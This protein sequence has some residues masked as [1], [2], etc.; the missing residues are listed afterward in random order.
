MASTTAITSASAP[1]HFA[2]AS[3]PSLLPPP[4]L[5]L[6]PSK[7]VRRTPTRAVYSTSQTSKTGVWSIREDL[8]VPSSPYFPVDAQARQGPPPMVQERFQSVISQLF[9]HINI[10]LF[11]T[12]TFEPRIQTNPKVIFILRGRWK[13]WWSK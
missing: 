7:H 9:Q 4:S 6:R 5:Q 2:F 13:S 1:K 8:V 12:R 10:K 3:K 11:G